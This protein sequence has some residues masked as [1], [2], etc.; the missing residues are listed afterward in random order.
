MARMVGSHSRSLEGP[1][2]E[3]HG[4]SDEQL[5]GLLRN[6][7]LHRTLDTRCFQ[8]NRQGKIPFAAGSEGHEALQAGAALAFNRGKDVLAPYYRDVGLFLGIGITALETL[9]SQ[10]ARATD[11]AAGRQFPQHFSKKSIG[12]TSFSSV[13]AAH[14]THAVGAAYAMKYRREEGRAGASAPSATER[15]ARASGMKP[16]TLRPSI[17]SRSSF[18]AKT[19]GSPSRSP[20][21]SRWRSKTSRTRAR[22]TA[23]RGRPSTASIPSRVMPRSN[24]R[25]RA[26]GG[27]GPVLLEGKV[28]RYLAHTTDDDDRTYRSREEVAEMRKRDPLPTYEAFLIGRG[29]C[30]DVA[31]AK[32]RAEVQ[33]EVDEA[34]DLAEAE[35]LPEAS[36]LY[37]QVYEGNYEPWQ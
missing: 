20:S 34:T 19:T 6:M 14:V 24:A 23:C 13:I 26:R 8:L 9:R 2:F 1:E 10:F 11:L 12:L 27:G 35:A 17:I 16:S 37:T 21:P 15:R 4:L 29:I 7:L 33:L 25:S 28:H 18:C 5:V 36:D 3:R 30:D 32:L 22:R 31:L